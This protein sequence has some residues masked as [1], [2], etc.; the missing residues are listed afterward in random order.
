MD[1]KKNAINSHL[2][3]NFDFRFYSIPLAKTKTKLN[4]KKLW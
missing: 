2:F 1:K 4:P 3:E